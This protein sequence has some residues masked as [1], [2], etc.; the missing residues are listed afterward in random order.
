[1]DLCIVWSHLDSALTLRAAGSMFFQNDDRHIRIQ[2]AITLKAGI[3]I[4]TAIKASNIG[5]KCKMSP[6][7]SSNCSY[8]KKITK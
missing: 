7:V 2:V 4:F 8:T 1:M 6:T 5:A 3:Q